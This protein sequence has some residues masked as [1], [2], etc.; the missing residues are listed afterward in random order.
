M[1]KMKY[2]RIRM[3]KPS[4]KPVKKGKKPELVPLLACPHC[5][6]DFTK[7]GALSVTVNTSTSKYTEEIDTIKVTVQ[8]DGF[9]SDKDDDEYEWDH[10]TEVETECSE[11]NGNVNEHMAS[12]KQ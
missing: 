8:P 3:V 5:H 9:L 12:V 11:C 6:A 10:G 7:K 4:D 2:I 1:A